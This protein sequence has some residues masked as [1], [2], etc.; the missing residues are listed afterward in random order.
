MSGTS[1]PSADDDTVSI[2]RAS[3]EE[4]F[5]VLAS[6]IRVEILLVM[7]DQPDATM[8]FSDLFGRV[9]VDDPGQF[10]YHLDRLVDRFVRKTDEGYELTHAGREIVGAIY[11]GTYTADAA[12][13][14]IPLEEP[15]ITCGGNLYLKYVD[16]AASI[17]CE[18][19]DRRSDDY[20]FPP[21]GL[22]QFDR[23]EL[24]EAIGRWIQK[25][26]QILMAGFCPTCTGKVDSSLVMDDGA[27]RYAGF[28][29][30]AAYRCRRCGISHSTP[31]VSPVHNHPSFLH[32]VFRHGFDVHTPVWE[33]YAALG[34]PEV[35]VRSTDPPEIEVSVSY[36][37]ETLTAIVDET[38]AV[39]EIG[40]TADPND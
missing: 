10:N 16:E 40:R 27:E 14:R 19:C 15:C 22:D 18:D 3:P 17:R 5:G 7:M 38:A 13:D 31:V 25:Y 29:A 30:H 11:A 35:E 1:T 21:R 39:T 33:I 20:P 6:D 37:G 34:R 4:I 12:V 36:E 26:A 32:F 24:A 8:A 9:D 28:P 23:E 2:R